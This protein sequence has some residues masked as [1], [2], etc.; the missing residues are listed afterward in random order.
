M[1]SAATGGTK[2]I[3]VPAFPT[4]TRTSPAAEP[5]D[6]RHPAGVSSTLAPSAVSAPAISSV[7]LARS[8][9][10]TTPGPSASAASTSARLVMDLEPGSRN[11][12][13]TGPAAAGAC[14]CWAGPRSVSRAAFM[15]RA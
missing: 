5:G 7:S 8:G 13:R 6:T 11:L 14:Q 10:P 1:V 15:L 3:T 9:L 2:R 12:A 4:S